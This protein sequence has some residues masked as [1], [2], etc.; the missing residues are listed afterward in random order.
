LDELQGFNALVL[1][2]L[3]V[4]SR[5]LGRVTSLVAVFSSTVSFV[6][7]L[8]FVSFFTGCLRRQSAK[9]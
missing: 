3:S 2:A 4:C 7:F 6:S 1:V 8:S 9:L 5:S